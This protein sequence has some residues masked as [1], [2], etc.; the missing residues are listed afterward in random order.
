[1]FFKKK[2]EVDSKEF[3]ELKK[4]IQLIW[5]EIDALTQR[6]KRKIK[7]P[8]TTDLILPEKPID[9]GFDELRKLNKENK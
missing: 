1:M 2:K 7:D 9:D 4:D 8:A 3:I 5:I 6:Y